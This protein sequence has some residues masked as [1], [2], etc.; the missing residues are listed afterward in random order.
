M[1]A[2][3]H[4]FA[5]PEASM[6]LRPAFHYFA[7]LFDHAG[8][9]VGPRLSSDSGK[10]IEPKTRIKRCDDESTKRLSAVRTRGSQE[11]A[12]KPWGRVRTGLAAGGSEI[13]TL[14]PPPPLRLC[15]GGKIPGLQAKTSFAASLRAAGEEREWVSGP[16]CGPVGNCKSRRRAQGLVNDAETLAHL[17]ETLH[18]RGIGVGVQ[19]EGQRDIGEADRR[20]AIHAQR[21]ARVPVALRDN[22]PAP[23]L[24]PHRGGNR[25]DGHT[26]PTDQHLH[27]HVPLTAPAP[28]PPR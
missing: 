5:S 14:G 9:V 1:L 11:A 19:F 23:Q 16:G 18:R 12:P 10:T 24:H 4:R 3:C 8:A 22:L 13:R 21:A 2:S 17:D 27:H 26:A 7:P 15:P 28:P 25:T 20:F 6:R